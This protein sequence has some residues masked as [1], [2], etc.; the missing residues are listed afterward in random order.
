MIVEIKKNRTDRRHFDFDNLLGVC[1]IVQTI[2][3]EVPEI[4]K[5]PLEPVGHGFLLA[6]GN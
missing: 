6:L 2:S 4:A 5:R 3:K 1:F